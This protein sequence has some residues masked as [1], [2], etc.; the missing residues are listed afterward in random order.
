MLPGPTIIRQCAA[1][2]QP[3]QQETLL[4]GN[5]FGATFWTDGKM[6]APML[7]ERHALIK[8]PHCQALLW[9][10]EQGILDEVDWGDQ[11]A[12]P[13]ARDSLVPTFADY[14]ALLESG[15]YPP[16]QERYLRFHAWWAGNQPRRKSATPSPLSLSE[17]EN[18]RHLA[19]LA[20]EADEE[21]RI[22]KAEILRELGQFDQ[23]VAL[24][25]Q[26]VSPDHA[27]ATAAIRSY[28]E[29][30]NPFVK[31]IPFTV[32][33]PGETVEDHLHGRYEFV[34]KNEELLSDE[35]ERLDGKDSTLLQV[36]RDIIDYALQQFDV[37]HNLRLRHLNHHGEYTV[38]ALIQATIDRLEVG[39]D[40]LAMKDEDDPDV[41]NMTVLGISQEVIDDDALGTL[42]LLRNL[43]L[44]DLD[45][46]GESAIHALIHETILR[47]EIA[48][49]QWNRPS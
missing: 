37:L 26:P 4:S 1:C 25:R 7:P 10:D 35:D 12:Y 38:Q 5:T 24:L 36:P 48:R 46:T 17:I 29:Q 45:Q 22:M 18:L 2:A 20:D 9:I 39:R 32:E 40:Y 44:R 19:A 11:N 47:L 31:K 3:F 28:A 49:E 16:E 41:I 14:L 43:H 30:A 33:S 42:D 15:D 6:E 13:E 34:Q 23:A 27:E 8:C 21:D